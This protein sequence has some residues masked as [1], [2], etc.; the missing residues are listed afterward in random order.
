MA[1]SSAENVAGS[2]TCV[3]AI[4]RMQHVL[5][6]GICV[7][8]PLCV[9]VRAFPPAIHPWPERGALAPH[10]R[11]LHEGLVSMARPADLADAAYLLVT[12]G[13]C[14]GVKSGHIATNTPSPPPTL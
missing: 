12:R 3:A 4:L 8:P 5:F 6:C 2:V 7:T 10:C 14:N 13:S 1:M 9:H 11:R